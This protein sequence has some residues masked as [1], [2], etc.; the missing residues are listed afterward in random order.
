MKTWKILIQIGHKF[1]TLHNSKSG[2]TNLLFDLII[3]L[4]NQQLDIEKIYLHAKNPDKVKYQFLINKKEC[5]DWRH[6]N[7]S[8]AFI[9]YS[10]DVDDINKSIELYN[11]NKKRKILIVFDDMML[12]CL[13][14]N[15]L[16]EEEN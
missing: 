7:D 8:K 1:P 11:P 13:V 12:I 3:D 14:M 2:E 5:T 15:I 6:F 9:K 4:I 10:N 16:L